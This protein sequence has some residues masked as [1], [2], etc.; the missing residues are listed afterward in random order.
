MATF[1]ER[2]VESAEMLGDEEDLSEHEME[3]REELL[4]DIETDRRWAGSDAKKFQHNFCT[5]VGEEDRIATSVV[6]HY[7]KLGYR[8]ER[9]CDDSLDAIFIFTR[10]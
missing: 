9:L 10:V 3:E 8:V 5:P 2:I 7:E 6:R 4:E 1:N